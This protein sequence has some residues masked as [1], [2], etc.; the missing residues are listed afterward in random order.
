MNSGLLLL[1]RPGGGSC[2]TR[3]HTEDIIFSVVSFYPLK[4]SCERFCKSLWKCPGER[5]FVSG[6]TRKSRRTGQIFAIEM[7]IIGLRLVR[8]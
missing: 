8:S 3:D 7:I 1:F 6:M 4:L 2:K 5:Q